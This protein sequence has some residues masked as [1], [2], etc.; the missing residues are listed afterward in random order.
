VL[1]AERRQLKRKIVRQPRRRTPLRFRLLAL[2]S[3][4][5][6]GLAQAP[7]AS[8]GDAR[9]LVE[10][11][12]F[13]S[14]WP[15]KLR[16][17]AGEMKQVY[18]EERTLG[19]YGAQARHESVRAIALG[20]REAVYGV[21]LS[22]GTRIQDWYAYLAKGA[23]G[24]QL[25]A[26]R[27]LALPPLFFMLLDSLAA[28]T[29]LPDSLAPLLENMRLVASSDSALKAFWSA[30]RPA[31]QRVAD[32][33]ARE[34][35]RSIAAAPDG[36]AAPTESLRALAEQLR[37][38][39]LRGAWRDPEFPGCVFIEIGGMID[40]EVGFMRC[41]LDG[42]VPPITPERFIL[43]EPVTAEWYLYKTT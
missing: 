32:N 33:F 6:V 24:W 14:A 27:T 41:A 30:Q 39:H 19:E 20:D 38:L 18:A 31:I 5:S 13:A 22:I 21:E 26:V 2:L 42:D 10:Q 43:V 4:P 37:D 1:L 23:S 25:R 3:L 35:V 7:S 17:Y 16:Y 29:T 34:T 36:L 9:W 12:F 40:N 8:P 11:F 28:A 15:D